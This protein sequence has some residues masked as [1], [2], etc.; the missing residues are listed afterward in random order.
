MEGER[1]DGAVR[2]EMWAKQLRSIK[3]TDRGGTVSNLGQR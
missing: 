3:L 2:P 1:N